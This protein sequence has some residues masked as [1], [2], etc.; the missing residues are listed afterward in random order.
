[1]K[2]FFAVTLGL[3]LLGV[4][5]ASF[6]SSASAQDAGW[7]T[8]F[9]GSTLDGWNVL[10]GANWSL[11]ESD[12]S[13]MAD[14]GIE[15]HLVTDSS[16][17][18]FEVIV[19]FWADSPT[20]S[21]VYIRCSDPTDITARNCYEVNISDM[22]ADPTYRTGAVVAVSPPLEVVDAGGRWNEYVIRADGPHL[23]VTLNGIETVNAQDSSHSAGVIGLQFS[24]GLIKFRSVRIRPL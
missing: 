4:A 19:E 16:Y 23:T 2:R 5:S 18:D 6:V 20:N 11:D 7:T 13:V 14:M 21:G 12:G 1:M 24:T 17:D 22:R 8:L 3:L 15:G 9:D 10:G